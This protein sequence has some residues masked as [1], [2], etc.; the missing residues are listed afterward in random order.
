MSLFQYSHS[1]FHSACCCCDWDACRRRF[2]SVPYYVI[3]SWAW[4]YVLYL[5]SSSYLP[6]QPSLSK[7]LISSLM[8]YLSNLTM[9][10]LLCS[11]PNRIRYASTSIVMSIRQL[12]GLFAVKTQACHN[13][14]PYPDNRSTRT[15]RKSRQRRSIFLWT[16]PAL[17]IRSVLLSR[18]WKV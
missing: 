16:A 6:S 7:L 14:S 13:I 17:M 10:Q 18:L 3:F 9:Y 8:M 5:H 12:F 15:W 2:Q 1:S 4:M 11:T